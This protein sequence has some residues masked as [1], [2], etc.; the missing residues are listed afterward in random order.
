LVEGHINNNNVTIPRVRLNYF[1]GHMFSIPRLYYSGCGQFQS[2][3]ARIRCEKLG[4]A[5]SIL[6]QEMQPWLILEPY[7]KRLYQCL[8][9]SSQEWR[10]QHMEPKNVTKGTEQETASDVSLQSVSG[11]LTT[12]ACRTRPCL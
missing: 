8:L 1:L 9:L 4:K 6:S 11:I 7:T 10:E 12:F 3:T 2:T 5:S